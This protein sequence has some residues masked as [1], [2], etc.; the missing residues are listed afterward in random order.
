VD[1][2]VGRPV[3]GDHLPTAEVAVQAAHAGDRVAVAVSAFNPRSGGR[4]G[5]GSV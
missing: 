5:G 1:D 4:A 3:G 2:D